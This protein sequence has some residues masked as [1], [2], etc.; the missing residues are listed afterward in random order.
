M[1]HLPAALLV[2]L[3]LVAPARAEVHRATLENGLRV[4]VIPDR[5]A[6]V[7]AT[8]LNYLVGSVDSPPGFPGTAHALEHMLFRGA[9][10]LDRDQLSELGALLGGAYNASTAETLTQYTYTVPATDLDLVLRIEA[11][12]MTGATIAQA[13]WAQERGAI[14]QEVSRN[15]SSPLYNLA[16]GIQARLFAGTPYEH[17]ALGTRASFEATDA[18]HLRAFYERWYAPNNAILVIAGDVD[19]PAAVDAARRA[20][21]AIPAR[22]VP[23]HAAIALPAFASQTLS[24]TGTL[25]YSLAAIALRAP[26]F[27]SP[28]FAAADVLGDILGSPRGPLAALARS[29]RVLDTH[30]SFQPKPD[31]GL[32]MATA[33]IP[34]GA[35]PAPALDAIRQVLAEA[36]AGRI[37]ADLVEAAKRQEIAQLAFATDSIAGLARTWSRALAVAGLDS[38]DDVIRAYEAV[39][40][41]SVARVARTMLDPAAMLTVTLTPVRSGPP[42]QPASFGA[43]E[44]HASEPARDVVLPEWARSA[45]AA[46]P[47]QQD[48]Q[49]PTVFTLSNGLRLIVVPQPG[50]RTVS[51]FGRVRQVADMQQP[52]GQDGVADLTD[53]LMAEGS[54]TRPRLALVQAMDD[55]AARHDTGFGFS[56]RTLVPA[57]EPAMRLLADAQL[58]PAFPEGP[59]AISRTQLA[60]AAAGQIDTPAHRAA[61]ALE[62]AL[63]PPNDPAL[64][65]ATPATVRAL[66]RADVQAY[67]AAAF[68]P[69]LATIVILGGITPEAARTIVEATFGPWQAEGPTPAIDLP[70]VGANTPSA[71]RIPDAA[72]QQ[73]RVTLAATLTLPVTDP[74]RHAL[75]LGNAILGGGFAS[76]LTQDLRVRTGYVYGV[77]SALDWTRTRGSHVI[78]FGADAADV[79]A[80]TALVRANLLRMQTTPVSPAELARAKAQSLRRL[81][82]QRASIGGIASL[83]LRLDELGL[84]LDTPQRTA[85][86]TQSLTAEDIR[87][88]FATWLR[89]DDLV[90]VIRGP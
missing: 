84:P 23:P 69:D 51:M 41:D 46:A 74:A 13:D 22:P 75:Q 49:S 27:R 44:R 17:T 82:M 62:R 88:A 2:L 36:A 73:D 58:N 4:V 10:G 14:N 64:R 45:L 31:A 32:A 25:P 68:R 11:G 39:T 56:L 37:P 1:R 59:L 20:F 15:L 72:S 26:G 77:S 53:R 55:L 65:D 16:A 52:P 18:A 61:E 6:P 67:Y 29:G 38:P 3:L 35:D 70:P 87:L 57:F 76:R 30:F 50:S 48:A 21:A 63:L 78:S 86:I 19:G 5:L 71:V 40:P 24:L 85:G 81:P 89:P 43:P 54:A 12:R 9:D 83:Y 33:S 34:P 80:A 8:A 60:E 28:D 79:P 66:T 47:A 90:Q 7:V 42:P